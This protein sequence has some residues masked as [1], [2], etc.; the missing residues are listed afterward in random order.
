[1]SKFVV[2]KKEGLK[3]N[4]DLTSITIRI[5]KDLMEQYATI[6]YKTNRS[7]NELIVMGL[8]YALENMEL[9]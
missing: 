9:K 5:E 8:R 4:D 1:M 2:T 7:R 3:K 6:A